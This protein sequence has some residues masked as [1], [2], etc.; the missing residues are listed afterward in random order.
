MKRWREAL[1]DE[2]N[3]RK[4]REEMDRIKFNSE[5]TGETMKM[6]SEG[7]VEEKITRDIRTKDERKARGFDRRVIKARLRSGEGEVWD[8]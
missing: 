5:E 6:W 1:K 3:K 2:N 7:G 4:E 8:V